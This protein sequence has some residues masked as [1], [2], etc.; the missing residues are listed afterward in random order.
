MA[1]VLGVEKEGWQVV[2]AVVPAVVVFVVAH[3]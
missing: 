1:E 2:A 3:G